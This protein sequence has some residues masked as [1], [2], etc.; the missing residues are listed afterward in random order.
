MEELSGLDAAFL[1]LE[2]DKIPMHIG[3]VSII[4][5]SMEF[6]DFFDFIEQRVHLVSKLT[7]KLVTVPLSIDKPYWA[8]DPDFDLNLHIR[9]IQLPAPGS[10]KELRYAASQYFSTKLD[11]NRPLWEFMFVEGLDNVSQVPKGS[12]ALITKVH[13]AGFDGKSGAD[14]M[15]MLYDISP[16]PRP[17]PAPKLKEKEQIP[18]NI[19]LVARGAYNLITKP[20]KLPSLLWDTGKATLKASY[21][22]RV[23]GI[24][25]P[26]LPFSAPKT[27]FNDVVDQERK[28][29]SALLELNRVKALRKVI[30]G[31][32]MNDVILAICS[33]ALRQYLLEKGELPEQPLVAMV[34]VSTRS[35]EEKNAM[36]NQV[37]AM[38][39][40]LATDIENPIKRLE[41]IHINTLVGKLYQD[42]IDAKSLM[43]FADLIPFGLAGVASRFYSR[44]ALAKWHK[45]FFN[46]VITNV[47]GPNVPLYLGGHKLLANMGTAPIFDGMGLI[48]PVL[49]YDGTI[50]ISPTSSANLMPDIDVFTKCILDSANEL[51]AA[52]QEKQT[53]MAAFNA[54]LNQK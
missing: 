26:T 46:L 15:A 34:P 31:A 45:P 38:Y 30:D 22:S 13:H 5:G 33:G 49:S 17:I 11:R 40:Q 10:W 52:V 8:D 1:F 37:S 35:R 9:K 19:N 3:G 42:A 14:L 24:K 28:W 16:T 32:T 23:H 29:N 7:Q 6:S 21:L 12:V 20:G 53:A 41:K 43:G 2:T 36:G 54:L 27:P 48:I 39:I 47:P 51:E 18:G 44:S 4:E 50:S 25:M